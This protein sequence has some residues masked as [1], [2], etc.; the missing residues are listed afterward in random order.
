MLIQQ[1]DLDASLQAHPTESTEFR[2][3][4]K[5]LK[6]I[7]ECSE[8]LKEIREGSEPLKEFRECS[9]PLKEFREGRESL[10]GTIQIMQH[11]APEGVIDEVPNQ[12]HLKTLFPNLSSARLDKFQA[13]SETSSTG[14]I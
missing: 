3:G 8:P 14:K 7:R 2:E 12:G 10:K 11:Q 1:R 9:E 13:T 6:E 5:S 4:S